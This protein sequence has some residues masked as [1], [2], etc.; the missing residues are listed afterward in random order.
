[1][2]GW[3]SESKLMA[4]WCWLI[5]YHKV[6]SQ[7]IDIILHVFNWLM[8]YRVVAT[9]EILSSVFLLEIWGFFYFEVSILQLKRNTWWIFYRLTPVFFVVYP[10][11]KKKK[12]LNLTT[13]RQ[14]KMNSVSPDQTFVSAEDFKNTSFSLP[15]HKTNWGS[16]MIRREKVELKITNCQPIVSVQYIFAHVTWLVLFC[17]VFLFA[18]CT[19]C[20]PCCFWTSWSA[21]TLRL[22]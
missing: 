18:G 20:V 9:T 19:F 13:F 11:F 21:A 17:F 12:C 7:K 16:Q 1:M 4:I 6:E 8:V 5:A 15:Q 3:Y 22:P 2:F 10:A 14:T